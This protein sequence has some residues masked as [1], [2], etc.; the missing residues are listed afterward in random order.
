MCR[1]VEKLIADDVVYKNCVCSIAEFS[2]EH[3]L[4]HG[5]KCPLG[6]PI[7]L[8]MARN[9]QFEAEEAAFLGVLL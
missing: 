6:L 9:L 7:V 2:A 1:D 4:F 8:W 3:C 5:T